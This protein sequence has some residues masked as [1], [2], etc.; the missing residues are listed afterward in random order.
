MASSSRWDHADR[1]LAPN[2]RAIDL[3]PLPDPQQVVFTGGA[4]CVYDHDQT[5]QKFA[6]RLK[7]G[8]AW[9]QERG[10]EV[11]WTGMYD[12]SL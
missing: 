6:Q 8:L 11:N 1:D 12:Y 2:K 5:R 4:F 3:A 10:V 9:H 7:T